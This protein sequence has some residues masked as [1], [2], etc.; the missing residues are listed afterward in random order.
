MMAAAATA[1]AA[2]GWD[3]DWVGPVEQ[4]RARSSLGGHDGVQGV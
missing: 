4:D 1:T 3:R 2:A